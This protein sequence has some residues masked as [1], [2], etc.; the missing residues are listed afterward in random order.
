M[1]KSAPPGNQG[2]AQT[3][4]ESVGF[5]QE[6]TS[7][8]IPVVPESHSKLLP[9]SGFD[10]A[11]REL[12]AQVEQMHSGVDQSNAAGSYFVQLP[13][14]LLT[15]CTAHVQGNKFNRYDFFQIGRFRVSRTA[16]L[17][18]S[19]KP[20]IESNMKAVSSNLGQLSPLH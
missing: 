1:K 17:I 9:A 4:G 20:V 14:L 6:K 8:S 3:D 19:L 12:E 5:E 2:D 18:P 16:R 15:R 13:G 7:S 11:G 10:S